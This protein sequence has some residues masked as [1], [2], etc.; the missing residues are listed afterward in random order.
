MINISALDNVIAVVVVILLLSLIVQS[1][2]AVLK[3]AFKIKSRQ[4]EDSLVDLF[5][6]VL[7]YDRE[8]ANASGNA[9]ASKGGMRARLV[10]MSGA[11]PILRRV[12]ELLAG[13][14]HPSN[15]NA[16]PDPAVR[17][18]F[19]EVTRGFQQIGRVAQ[20]GKRMLDSVSKEDL[21]KVMGKVLPNSLLP[22]F[23][24]KLEAACA[25]VG[26][27]DEA[28]KEINDNYLGDLSGDASA[29]FAAMQQSLAPL[30]ND[31]RSVYHGQQVSPALI[32]GD[33]TNLRDIKLGDALDILGEIQQKVKTDLEAANKAQANGDPSA[34][35][36]AAALTALS[37]ALGKIAQSLTKL[38]GGLDA[39]ITPLRAKLG[40]VETWYAAVMQS[41]E[42][43]Y[44]RGMKTWAI[45]ISF[46]VVAYLNANV[47]AIYK[48]IAANDALRSRL[49]Q[50]GEERAKTREASIQANKEADANAN[51]TVKEINAEITS[52]QAQ[53]GDYGSLGFQPLTWQG[54]KDRFNPGGWSRQDWINRRKEDMKTLFGW[55]VMTLLLSVGAPFWQDTLESLFGVKNL[56]RKR[57][58]TKNVEGKSGAGQPRP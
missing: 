19:D 26:G 33:I 16:H 44:T 48:N 5:E 36:H 50:L 34:V 9:A 4:I 58:D 28:I 39:A 31:L 6:N 14:L 51:P 46:L 47:F 23:S 11:S 30:L 21:E 8:A 1:I 7:H 45:V 56:L 42:E 2:Q 18:L 13:G 41:F 17:T 15:P 24:A 12:Y 53:I 32:I 37:A 57:S 3:K 22:G 52:I 10:R 49:V 38:S 27:L 20:T 54:V 25:Y 29:K 43:R 55:I 35:G 40:E